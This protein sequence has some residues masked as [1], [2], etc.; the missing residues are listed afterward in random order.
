MSSSQL[1]WR[2][3]VILLS[4][5][6]LWAAALAAGTA[7][8]DIVIE[9]RGF[10]TGG[11]EKATDSRFLEDYGNDGDRA[12]FAGLT[13]AGINLHM[14]GGDEF[15]VST[16]FLAPISRSNF[17]LQLEWG[18]LSWNPSQHLAV[19]AGR[20]VAPVWMYSQQLSVGYS[21]PWISVP[22]EVYGLNPIT[23]LNGFSLLGRVKLGPGILETELA[24]GNG[25]ADSSGGSGLELSDTIVKY[26]NALVLDLRYKWDDWLLLRASAGRAQVDVVS[27]RG[28]EIPAGS[29]PGIPVPT[30]LT[31]RTPLD[32]GTAQLFSAGA[33]IELAQW[34][35]ISELARR[36]TEGNSLAR[37]T[38]GFVTAGRRFGQ[39][40]PHLTFAWRGDLA[41]DTYTHPD[42]PAVS[43]PLESLTSISGCLNFQASDSVILKVAFRRSSLAYADSGQ[44]FDFNTYRAAVDFVF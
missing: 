30:E 34:V 24:G 4:L 39:V 14:I 41:G 43:T 19:R 12:N 18:F 37:A 40:F 11:V 3:L 9:T 2:Q 36:L 8:A 38:A 32:V 26:T 27:I 20:V 7:W 25:R 28:L 16:Q 6:C 31:L 13:R 1:R 15:E 29:L 42:F 44:D 22:A 33:R 5:C 17:G 35:L 23:A 21:F 10:G